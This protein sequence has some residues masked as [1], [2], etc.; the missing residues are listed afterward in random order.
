[1]RQ[2]LTGLGPL[3]LGIATLAI[4]LVVLLVA[5]LVFGGGSDSPPGADAGDG[6]PGPTI[7]VV[8]VTFL[9][10]ESLPGD[11]WVS[12]PRQ[13]LAN[14][15]DARNA[16]EGL[17]PPIEECGALRDFENALYIADPGFREGAAQEFERRDQGG[18]FVHISQFVAEFQSAADLGDSWKIL[19]G[20]VASSSH[21]GCVVAAAALE[22]EDL[23][24]EALPPPTPPPGG[25]ATAMKYSSEVGGLKV[26]LTQVMVWWRSG[27]TLSSLSILL[28]GGTLSAA[29]IESIVEA[30]GGGS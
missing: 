17:S 15:L 20:I 12:G 18:G 7:S 23:A 29:D 2:R 16:F 19:E 1:M 3:P 9:D 5:Y 25:L 14:V 10:P 27:V 11:G 4:A 13:Q 22:D 8:P 30:A 24:A 28:T 26:E 6:T 21:L